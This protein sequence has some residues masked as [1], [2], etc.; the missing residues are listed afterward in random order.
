[1]VPQHLPNDR[2]ALAAFRRATERL[3]DSGDGALAGFGGAADLMIRE[4]IAKTNIHW[5]T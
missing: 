1:M 4:A 5:R 2:N 3:I